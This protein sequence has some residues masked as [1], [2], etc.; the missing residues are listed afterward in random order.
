MEHLF[1]YLLA[2]YISSL[3]NCL[4]K[5]LAHFL[6]RLLGCLLLSCRSSLYSLDI[7]EP[8]IFKVSHVQVLM[9]TLSV[10]RQL[11]PV[12]YIPRMEHEF[13]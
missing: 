11:P 9:S 5:S 12:V 1:I 2:I 10:M 6:M 3:K 13:Q 7:R 8:Q 4:C